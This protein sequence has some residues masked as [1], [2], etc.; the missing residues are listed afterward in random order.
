MIPEYKYQ[1]IDRSI[2]TPP[3]KEYLVKPLMKVVPWQ[4]PANIITVVSNLFLVASLVTALNKDIEQEMKF[5]LSAVFIFIYAVGDHMDGMQA[6]RT[7][8]S[9]PLGEFFDH[10]LDA[11]NTG[12][13]LMTVLTLYQVSN[14]FI[15]G[16]I[17][18][19]NY[20][21]HASLFYEQYKTGWLIFER[22]GSLE[23]VITASILL[24]ISCNDSLFSFLMS[25][26]FYNLK[27]IEV[28]FLA[29]SVGALFTFVKTIVR[30]GIT[31]VRFYSFCILL[32][33][34]TIL[35]MF[36]FSILFTGLVISLYSGFYI[37]NLQHVH[38]AGGKERLPDPGIP[39]LLLLVLLFPRFYS[40]AYSL[41]IL[42]YIAAAVC[43][44]A[45]KTVYS[46][47][48]FWVWKN[49]DEKELIK[50]IRKTS[51]NI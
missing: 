18:C 27:V 39:L 20:L 35:G 14:P 2:I 30:A 13:L 50:E 15:I 34:I 48:K 19:V 9:S 8:T 41:L 32:T 11:F 49:P 44:L 29:A 28:L 10:F 23:A 24:L 47:R 3:F 1:V 31:Q 42:F 36:S 6:K 16:F 51:L 12:I 38:L 7:K 40:D 5:V 43:Y 45:A 37:G 33:L 4:I 17:L 21:A 25:A 46:L 22:I 26:P